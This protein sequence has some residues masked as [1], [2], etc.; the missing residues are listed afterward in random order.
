VRGLLRQ[1]QTMF[2]IVQNTNKLEGQRCN[3]AKFMDGGCYVSLVALER[4]LYAQMLWES[5]MGGNGSER[6]H[7]PSMTLA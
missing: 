7:A 3:S 2:A 5:L 6:D 1:P 4:D